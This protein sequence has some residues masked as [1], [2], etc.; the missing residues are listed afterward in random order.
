MEPL[1]ICCN[2]TVFLRDGN[3]TVCGN[4]MQDCGTVTI[5]AETTSEAGE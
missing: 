2:A 5:D 3:I 1:S 4:C